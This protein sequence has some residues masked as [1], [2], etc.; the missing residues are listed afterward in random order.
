M[1]RWLKETYS[2]PVSAN[3]C[4]VQQIKSG[5]EI[6]WQIGIQYNN[7]WREEREGWKWGSVVIHLREQAIQNS[8]TGLQDLDS[9]VLLQATIWLFWWEL[10]INSVTRDD[11]LQWQRYSNNINNLIQFHLVLFHLMRIEWLC[12]QDARARIVAALACATS[13][14]VCTSTDFHISFQVQ[15]SILIILTKFSQ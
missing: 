3:I 15:D 4:N 10:S 1:Y 11:N 14:L 7:I 8:I 9:R 13:D 5:H 12:I 6:Q 2:I